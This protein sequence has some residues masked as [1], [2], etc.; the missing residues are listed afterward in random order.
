M[1]TQRYALTLPLL[2]LTAWHYLWLCS[3]ARTRAYDAARGA[4]TQDG[5]GGLDVQHLALQR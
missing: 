2:C 3:A 4:V 5:A 1:A